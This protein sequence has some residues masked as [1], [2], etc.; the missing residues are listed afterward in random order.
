[1]LNRTYVFCG[2]WIFPDTSGYLR[3]V[4][5]DDHN[6]YIPH[7]KAHSHSATREKVHI[8]HSLSYCF[9]NNGSII[10][11]HFLALQWKQNSTKLYWNTLTKTQRSIIWTRYFP[12]RTILFYSATSNIWACSSYCN[13]A[14]TEI[15]LYFCFLIIW[16]VAYHFSF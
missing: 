4:L 7:I 16:E 5:C 1:M 11:C 2:L 14:G 9:L 12:K 10:L 3:N 15:Y 6:N 13:L 8:F